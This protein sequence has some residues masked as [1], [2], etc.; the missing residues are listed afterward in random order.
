MWTRKRRSI[1]RLLCGVETVNSLVALLS[2][3]FHVLEQ[4]AKKELALR[5]KV[6]GAT[7][8]KDS[9]LVS[10]SG[11]GSSALEFERSEAVGKLRLVLSEILFVMSKLRAAAAEAQFGVTAAAAGGDPASVASSISANEEFYWRNSELFEDGIYLEEVSDV[12]CIAQAELPNLLQI[13]EL[14]DTL[15]HVPNGDWLICRLV[16]NNAD[17]FHEVCHYLVAGAKNVGIA[18]G[19][20]ESAAEDD[21]DTRKRCEVLR[22]LIAMNPSQALS[23]RAMAVNDGKL[24]ELAIALTLEHR[25][26]SGLSSDSSSSSLAL[27]NDLLEFSSGLLLNSDFNARGWFAHFVRN[28]QKKKSGSGINDSFSSQMV[29]DFRADLL[30]QLAMVLRQSEDGSGGEDSVRFVF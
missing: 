24:P 11:S 21:V 25:L 28:D 14:A 13:T 22:A 27:P 17:A 9:N 29:R 7:Q 30:Q 4:D 20:G 2:I 16:A 15:L 23:I 6:G 3:D 18:G 1:L 26:G 10:T 19:G 12:L 5:G 8:L